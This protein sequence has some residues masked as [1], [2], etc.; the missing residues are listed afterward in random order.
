MRSSY[1]GKVT[2][3][4]HKPSMDLDPDEP[5]M[6]FRAQDRFYTQ[7]AEFY[8]NLCATHYAY[9]AA[10]RSQ[11]AYAGGQAWQAANPDRVKT[12]D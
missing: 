8:A 5:C 4:N 10:E 3:E 7:V 9:A 11:V 1:Y 6:V 12:P 2:V